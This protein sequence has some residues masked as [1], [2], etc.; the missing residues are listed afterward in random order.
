MSKFK[1]V[2]MMVMI[3]FT[4][5]MVLGGDAVAA[6]K[7]KVTYRQV[8]YTTTIHTLKVPDV[9]GHTNTLIEAK[10]ISFY[11]KWGAAVTSMVFTMDLIKGIG[12]FQGYVLTTYPDGSTATAKFEG[13]STA[14]GAT[15]TGVAVSEGTWT[16][17]KGT[18]K[19]QGIQGGGPFKSYVIAPGQFYSDNEGE[20]TLP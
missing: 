20:Y 17:T 15:L 4:M 16:Y 1:I 14:A 12:T 11:D 9:E 7:G 3:A 5:G 2:G 18:G 10:G 8:N 13:K 6:E 19:F